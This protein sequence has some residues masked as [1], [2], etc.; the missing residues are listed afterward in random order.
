MFI[1]HYTTKKNISNKEYFNDIRV[2]ITVCKILLKNDC[3][4][5]LFDCTKDMSIAI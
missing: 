2:A 5:S 4:V 1:V 3:I